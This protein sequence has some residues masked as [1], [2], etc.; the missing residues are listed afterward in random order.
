MVL[1]FPVDFAGRAL[2][3]TCPLTFRG[4]GDDRIRTYVLAVPTKEALLR[5]VELSLQALPVI[6]I[7]ATC[8]DQLSYVSKVPQKDSMISPAT[9][10][11]GHPDC[12]NKRG[13]ITELPS[14]AQGG[15][16]LRTGIW[17]SGVEKPKR[18]APLERDRDH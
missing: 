5:S 18:K 11:E 1:A 6:V 12:G 14:E 8:S 7:P 17:P 15:P 10:S 3:V 13:C 16:Y 4:V 9:A 2:V